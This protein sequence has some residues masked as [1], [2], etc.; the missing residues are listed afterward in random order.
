MDKNKFEKLLEELDAVD[1]NDL[2]GDDF[3]G[4]T[5]N[6]EKWSV[7]QQ[8]AT[9]LIDVM[10]KNDHILKVHH[11][12]KPNPKEEFASVMVVMPQV[13]GLDKEAKAAFALAATLCDRI[14]I[15]T[16]GNKIRISFAVD[17]IWKE[18]GNNAH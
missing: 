6:D 8:I 3:H 4:T 14:A 2:G 9:A 11:L 12:S 16:T 13:I 5:V 1:F 7:Y 15:T 18:G 10:D 17:N